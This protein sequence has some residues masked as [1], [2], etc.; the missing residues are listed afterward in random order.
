MIL[1]SFVCVCFLELT[2]KARC[3]IFIGI[4]SSFTETYAVDILNNPHIDSAVDVRSECL[5]FRP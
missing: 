2:A 4:P 3:D 5:Y 1:F